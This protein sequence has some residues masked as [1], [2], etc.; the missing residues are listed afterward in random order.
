M[1]RSRDF[2]TAAAALD[3]APAVSGHTESPAPAPVDRGAVWA[4]LSTVIDP[5]IGL[6]I[7]TLGMVYSVAMDEGEVRVTYTLTTPGCPMEAAITGGVIHAVSAVEGV[8]SVLPELVWEPRWNP[9]MIQEG[10]W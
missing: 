9:T 8:A 3:N 1:N 7:V 10:A 4:A 6:D 2:L 5:E